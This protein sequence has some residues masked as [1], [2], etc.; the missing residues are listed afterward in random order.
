MGEHI[1]GRLVQTNKQHK[2]QPG[3]DV[4]D[5]FSCSIFTNERPCN[6]TN[7]VR[8]WQLPDSD[9][10]SC[11]HGLCRH[12]PVCVHPDRD[13]CDIGFGMNKEDPLIS[14][15]WDAR[16]PHLRCTFD[17]DKINTRDQVLKFQD[18]FGMNDD[19]EMK[20]CT[21]KVQTCPN[22][23]KN[24]S[25][26]KSIGEGG[27]EC[28]KWFEKQPVNVQDASIQNYCLRNNTDDCKCVNRSKSDAYRT[29]KG[30]YV[31]SDGCW[32]VP[33]ANKSGQYL[34]PSQ[35]VNPTC[36]DNVCTQVYNFVKTRDVKLDN[37]KNDIMCD[38]SSKTS[39]VKPVPIPGPTPEI[40]PDVGPPSPIDFL[41]EFDLGEFI[42]RNYQKIIF[43]VVIIILITWMAMKK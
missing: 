43:V 38:F 42:R 41:K 10:S 3:K 15:D 21:Q 23:M 1:I 12:Q 2:Y 32:Y 7:G 6:I 35:L 4:C 30:S 31:F 27:D 8:D 39:P 18:K 13:E 29:A 28:R 36:P 24:C 37:I 25:R 20:Y 33:C 14:Y 22:G 19:I 5:C 9:E 17:L 16:A 40:E 34:V 26:L 11:C